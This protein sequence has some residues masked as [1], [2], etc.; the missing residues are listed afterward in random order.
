VDLE[1]FNWLLSPP[2]QALLA[3]LAARP[4]RE[5]DTLREMERLRQRVPPERGR[6]ALELAL[7]R[8]RAGAKF[9][10]AE[11]LYFTREA[12]EQASAAPVAAH[13][14]T[15]LA[16]R[17]HVADL[18]CGIGGD[19][20]ALATA[21]ARVTAVERDP[22]RLA[23]A[24]ANAEALGLS[25]RIDWRLSDLA[26]AA[27]PLANALFSDPGRRVGG[28]RRFHVESYDPP[29]SRVLAWRA[30][31][32]ALAVKVAP[33]IDL[34]ALPADAEIEFVS[35]DGELKEVV[36]WCGPLAQVA[37]RASLLRV[38]ANGQVATSTLWARPGAIPPT[39]PLA[40]PDAFLY[41][42]DPAVIRAG[43]VTDLA[44]QLEAA[45]LD[46][47]IAYLTAPTC[48]ATPFARAWRVLEWFPFSL[49]RLRSRL[50][51]L[52]AG[53]VTVK[54]R[55]SPL[56]SDTLARQ[57]SGPGTRPLV[58]VLTQVRGRP[59]ALLCDPP[60]PPYQSIVEMTQRPDR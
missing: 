23:M 40:E 47:T 34:A 26:V 39:A 41:E 29:L 9:P 24:R 5:G 58:V 57:L 37:R 25:E 21:G 17:G 38:E 54:K 42:P 44:L 16:P 18:G 59:V 51:E 13:R 12:L 32:P 8:R 53:P 19:T 52:G 11:R 49:K 10:A 1:I 46:P 33:G 2:G 60:V 30:Y 6:A 27:P 3:E 28:Q 7:L 43:L 48:V 20:L 31:N 36:I 22:L 4:L 45:Q 14:A 15:R 35:L 56:D 50:R 55:G